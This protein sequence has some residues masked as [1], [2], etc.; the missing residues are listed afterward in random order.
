MRIEEAAAKRQAQIDS[1][2]EIIIG[3]NKYQVS[4]RRSN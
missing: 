3:V 1:G 4:R 2:N